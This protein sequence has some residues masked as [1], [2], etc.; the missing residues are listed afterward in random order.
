MET[1]REDAECGAMGRIYVNKDERDG[2]YD[3]GSLVTYEPKEDARAAAFG[4]GGSDFATMDE[5]CKK[6][7]GDETAETIDVYEAM[8]MFLPGMFAYRSILAGGVPME[9]PDLRDPAQRDKWRNDTACSDPKA[10]C[11]NLW[12]TFSKGTPEIPDSVYE[13]VA[14]QWEAE[15]NGGSYVKAVAAQGRAAEEKK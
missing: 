10:A 5:F 14:R 7:L 8:D 6:I 11:G 12:P 13:A 15:K 2:A 4:H 1:A 3:T 9:I